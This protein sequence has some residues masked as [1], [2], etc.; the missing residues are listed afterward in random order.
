MLAKRKNIPFFDERALLKKRA[1][2]RTEEARYH[3]LASI[4]NNFYVVTHLQ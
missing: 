2:H 4:L 3:S 1:L